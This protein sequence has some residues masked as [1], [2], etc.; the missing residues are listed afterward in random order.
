MEPPK[1][2]LS[3]HGARRH[4]AAS[5]INQLP[6][7]R[8]RASSCS[9]EADAAI[10]GFIRCRLRAFLGLFDPADSWKKTG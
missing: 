7:D 5:A 2:V 4:S 1:L 8:C 10:G 9:N 3:W 6:L